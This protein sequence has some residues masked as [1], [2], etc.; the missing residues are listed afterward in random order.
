MA[1]PKIDPEIKAL[2][3]PPS[4]DERRLLR[5]KLLTEGFRDSLIVW[6]ETDI[7]LDGHTR[8]EICEEHRLKYYTERLKFPS[9][10]LAIQWVLDNQLG[11]RNLTDEKRAYYMGKEYLNR[12]QQEV[13]KPVGQ[14]VPPGTRASQAVAEKHGVNEKTVR[15]NAEFAE[16]VDTVAEKEGLAAKEAILN[17][18]A[19]KSKAEVIDEVAPPPASKPRAAKP[20]KNGRVLFD[21]RAAEAKLAAARRVQDD[22][23]SAYG[24]RGA[25]G[26]IKEDAEY[27]AMAEHF[28]KWHAALKARHVALAKEP[29]PE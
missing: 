18:T 25:K 16:A 10:E 14:N 15:R 9:R 8:L 29:A 21:W 19:G 11:R 24:L 23:Y 28:A 6:D 3:D 4:A 13:G 20:P 5:I 22:L 26:P 1:R 27:R 2:F 7:L 17:G 12:K